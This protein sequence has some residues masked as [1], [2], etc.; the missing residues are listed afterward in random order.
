MVEKFIRLTVSLAS[1]VGYWHAVADVLK[2]LHNETRR[3]R[4]GELEC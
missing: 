1:L 2:T 3:K 4:C